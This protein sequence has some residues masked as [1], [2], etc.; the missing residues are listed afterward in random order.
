MLTAKHWTEH[1]NHNG[2]VAGRTEGAEGVC[3]P[4]GGT[5]ISTNKKEAFHHG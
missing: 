3:N 2:G 1:R 5:I 4:M